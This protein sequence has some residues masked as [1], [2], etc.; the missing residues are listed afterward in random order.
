MRRL[1]V[2][3]GFAIFIVTTGPSTGPASTIESG[4]MQIA[5]SMPSA[6]PTPAPAQQSR[7]QRLR[8][9]TKETW[10]QMKRRWS[11]QRERYASCRKEARAQRLAGRKTRKFLE[12]CMDR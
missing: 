3:V 1:V 9:R 2:I 5:Q 10:S 4:A 8:E 11:M 7:V 6:S 12:D